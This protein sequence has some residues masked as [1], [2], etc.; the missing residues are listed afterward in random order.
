MNTIVLATD[1]SPSARKATKE[2]I[3]LADDTAARLVIVG[4]EHV[5][6]PA[7]G[8]YG[9]GEV[10]N[11]LVAGEHIQVERVLADASHEA[12]EAGVICETVDRKGDVVE[13]ICDVAAKK[14]ARVIVVGSHG[15]SGVRRFIFGSVSTGVLHHAPC[16][17]LVVRGQTEAPT[18]RDKV[19]ADVAA[20]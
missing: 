16:P 11:E 17:V 6:M 13:A 19:H 7:Y 1:G 20:I 5:T 10:C 12:D 3:R 14:E 8:F 15:W 2:A 4:V 18:A 9:Y